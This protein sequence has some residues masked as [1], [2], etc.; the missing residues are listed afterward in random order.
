MDNREIQKQETQEEELN[1]QES[2]MKRESEQEHNDFK[3][4]V[5][6][7]LRK[8]NEEGERTRA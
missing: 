2:E 7:R 5:K 6:G 3:K 4:A 8:R 1:N